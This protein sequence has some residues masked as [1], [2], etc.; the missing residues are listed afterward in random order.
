MEALSVKG[1]LRVACLQ[2]CPNGDLAQNADSAFVLATEAA[3]NGA[4][5]LLLPEYAT[6]IL[7]QKTPYLPAT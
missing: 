7:I 5:L 2:L 3:G 6:P 1:A 4:Q